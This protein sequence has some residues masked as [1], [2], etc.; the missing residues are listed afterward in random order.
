MLIAAQAA[1]LVSPGL[2]LEFELFS[3]PRLMARCHTRWD[4]YRRDVI[5]TLVRR[6]TLTNSACVFLLPPVMEM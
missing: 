1:V 4:K 5:I 2:Q 6:M 3:F